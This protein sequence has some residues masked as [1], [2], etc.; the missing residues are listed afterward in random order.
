ML[1]RYHAFEGIET[2]P[3][4]CR[5]AS[6]SDT[7]WYEY[8]SQRLAGLL[9]C[10]LTEVA[11]VLRNGVVDR[12]IYRS[13]SME[14]RIRKEIKSREELSVFGGNCAQRAETTG[15]I[16]AAYKIALREGFRHLVKDQA[17][18]E[19]LAGRSDLFIPRFVDER[20]QRN[21]GRRRAGKAS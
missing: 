7:I 18:I 8:A 2:P 16:E 9:D 15:V 19:I 12:R 14:A 6:A 20:V 5:M 10:R 13:M 17:M 11:E 3:S 1:K 4:I 21:G